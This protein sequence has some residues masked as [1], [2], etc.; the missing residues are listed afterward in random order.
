MNG[1]GKYE[2]LGSTCSTHKWSSDYENN[3]ANHYHVCEVCGAKS[4][5]TDNDMEPVEGEPDVYKDVYSQYKG[6][7]VSGRIYFE[8]SYYWGANIYLHHWNGTS[9]SDWPGDEMHY[10]T[11]NMW[12]KNIFY[13]DTLGDCQNIIFHNNNGSQTQNGSVSSTGNA[14]YLGND[15]YIGGAYNICETSA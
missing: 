7:K 11:T 3:G 4:K 2:G 15:S 13:V 9:P 6:K 8:D 1:D 5:I 10:F 12:G 14:Y